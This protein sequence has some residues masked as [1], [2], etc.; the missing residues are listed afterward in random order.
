[1]TKDQL[2][3]RINDLEWED[4]E[5]KQAKSELPKNIWE[6]V[7]AF[8]NT[9]GGWILLGIK[10]EGKIFTITGTDNLEKLEQDINNTLSGQQKFNSL[11]RPTLERWDFDGLKVLGCYIPLSNKKPIYFNSPENTFI[12]VGSADIRATKAEVDAMF[13][14]Q[15]FGTRTSEIV[16]G[17]SINDLNQNSV[18]RYRDYMAR[19]NKSLTYNKL[20]TP[21]FLT[22]TGIIVN[23]NL[24]Y[25][26]LLFL[27]KQEKIF[28]H[29]PDFRIDLLEIPGT[30]YTDASV[31]YTYRL[32]EQENI[33]EY[34]FSVFE[35]VNQ[36][37]DK[38]FALTSEGFASEEYPYIESLREAT[39]NM[40]MHADYFSPAKPR[41]RIFTNHIEFFNPGG[42]PKPLKE[43]LKT[44]ISLPRNQIIAKLFRLVKLAENAGFGFD[45]IISGWKTFGKGSVEF[46]PGTDYTIVKFYLTSQTAEKEDTE[47]TAQKTEEDSSLKGSLKGSL[48]SSLKII[49]LMKGNSLITIPEIAVIVGITER[50]VKKHISNLKQAGKI[51]RIGPDKGGYWEV[52]DR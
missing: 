39:V 21:E 17:S 23:E 12:R 31:R 8:S 33:W 18:E 3:D 10:Q 49:E 2:V 46:E 22:K 43:L 4:F 34:Y 28:Q 29:I 30:S 41:V 5:V 36:K 45:K 14:D 32:A 27:G 48:K 42:L 24:T 6:T 40:L 20:L 7:S 15:A 11:I 13:R 25:G 1:M 35:R 47:K 52:T 9:N 50:G 37:I 26:G 38:P 51:K 44:D 16:P 19:F